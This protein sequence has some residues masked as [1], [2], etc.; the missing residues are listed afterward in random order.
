MRRGTKRQLRVEN[1][2]MHYQDQ[3]IKKFSSKISGANRFIASLPKLL[4]N[5]LL[6][7]L[8]FISWSVFFINSSNAAETTLDT[9][10]IA[11]NLSIERHNF[12]ITNDDWDWLKRKEV[13]TVG[14]SG[15]EAEPFRVFEDND[16]YEGISSDI[17]SLISQLIG[18]KVKLVFYK[19]NTEAF[20]A[21]RDGL[22]D[23]VSSHDHSYKEKF[24]FL[25]ALC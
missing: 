21:L 24:S 7:H 20:T 19:S 4:K 3:K 11:S 12:V 15:E 6:F 5:S 18:L 13:L 9:Q 10:V 16:K 23:I 2:C 1:P 14:I 25:K 22:V 17:T 8:A